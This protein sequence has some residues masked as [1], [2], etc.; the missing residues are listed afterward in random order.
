MAI[1]W[2]ITNRCNLGKC[3]FCRIG[4]KSTSSI[5]ELTLEEIKTIAYQYFISRS[6]DRG[7]K[8][9]YITGG[10]P[11]IRNDFE[12]IINYIT[13]DLRIP[14][15]IVTNG[16]LVKDDIINSLNDPLIE[17]NFS[18]DGTEEVHNKIRKYDIFNITLANLIKILDKKIN[19]DLLPTVTK[20]NYDSLIS[21]KFTRLLN[22]EL[23]G[24]RNIAFSQI[25]SIGFG[26][27]CQNQNVSAREYAALINHVRDS[28]PNVNV[29][30]RKGR[31]PSIRIDCEGNVH[32]LAEMTGKAYLYDGNLRTKTLEEIIAKPSFFWL[33]HKSQYSRNRI[34]WEL[35][36]YGQKT[37]SQDISL[38]KQIIKD[39]NEKVYMG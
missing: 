24:I 4:P 1:A 20:V 3:F 34:I 8:K 22:Y 32:V 36:K 17:L 37:Y 31:P 11:F 29:I 30:M 26:K 16:T 35:I 33:F 5:N 15:S 10:E 19:V 18:L 9:I 23:I 39:L 13:K 28:C 12:E 38:I 25:D 2:R 14:L 6:I 21:S 7:R 27:N